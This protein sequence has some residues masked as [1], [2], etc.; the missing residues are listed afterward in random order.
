MEQGFALFLEID[1]LVGGGQQG[2]ASVPELA[3]LVEEAVAEF[4]RAGLAQQ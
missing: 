1:D 3:G 2:A 4:L